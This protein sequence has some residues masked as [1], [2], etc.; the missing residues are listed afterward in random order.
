MYILTQ[1]FCYYG[2][3]FEDKHFNTEHL[4]NSWSPLFGYFHS[5]LLV[6][7]R[8]LIIILIARNLWIF[9]GLFGTSFMFLGGSIARLNLLTWLKS[10]NAMVFLSPEML[11]SSICAITV[12]Q[13][14]LLLA[15]W[16]IFDV[17]FQ[18]WIN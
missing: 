15:K 6:G 1:S 3:F 4:T 5:I 18:K 16:L 10:S 12:E 17:M 11:F 8:K 2:Y 13:L 14:R 9:F 7:W